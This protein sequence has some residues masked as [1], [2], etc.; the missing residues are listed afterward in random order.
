MNI[1]AIFLV[2]G[3]GADDIFVL[4][5]S[6]KQSRVDVKPREVSERE[7]GEGGGEEKRNT[8]HRASLSHCTYYTCTI[9]TLLYTRRTHTM[10][11]GSLYSM[12]IIRQRLT[13]A[14]LCFVRSF[15]PSF[16]PPIPPIPPCPISL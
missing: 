9:H 14:L 3:V 15:V 12:R 16:L 10:G 2:L 13:H 1:L 4:V 6:W 11:G 5:D 7:G 8:N